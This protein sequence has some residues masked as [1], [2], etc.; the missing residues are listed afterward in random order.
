MEI[1]IKHIAKLS[2]LHIEEEK[3][4]KF[5]QDMQNIIQM[6]EKLPDV[7]DQTLGVDRNNPMPLREDEIRPS[8]RRDDVLANAP[9]T[10]AGCVVV[11]KTVE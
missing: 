3:I 7:K 6:V 5:Q 11:P 9:K 1:D 10:A 4:L 2:R 8:M